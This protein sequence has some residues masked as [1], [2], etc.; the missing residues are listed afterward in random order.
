MRASS[1]AD[2]VA[3][4][5]AVGRRFES[6]LARHFFCMNDFS[7]IETML[8]EK[9]AYFLLDLH[10]ERLLNSADFFSFSY[11]EKGLILKLHEESSSFNPHEKYRVRLLLEKDGKIIIT[12]E[13]LTEIKDLPVKVKFSEK[14]VD[15]G[16]SFLKHKTTNRSLY[17][18]ELEKIRE[19]GFFDCLFF[20]ESGEVTEG[21]ITN[22]IIKKGKEYFTPPT[23]SGLL[24]GTYR[25]HLLSSQEVPLK[26]KVLYKED[27]LN[28]DEIF[29]VN[30]VRKMLRAKLLV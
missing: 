30:S 6:S 2:R 23:S 12:S 9:G 4:Y 20:N 29:I 1:S 25:E 5:E 22:V 27:L 28:A 14:K 3:A 13:P 18:S 10:L 26:E 19:E 15:K 11:S 16:D 7:L 17:G 24:P 8:W 21:A